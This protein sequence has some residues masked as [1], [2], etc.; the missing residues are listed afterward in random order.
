[1]SASGARFAWPL[2]WIN[3]FPG[4]GKLT[5]A[6]LLMT[7]L[8]EGDPLLIDNHSLIDP[9]ETKFSRGHPNYQQE[10]RRGREAVFKN[11]VDDPAFRTRIVIFTAALRGRRPF[12]PIY[13]ECDI[14]E[15]IRR[16][17]SPQRGG[18]ETT[19][20]SSPEVLAEMRS[21]CQLFRFD[22]VES[23]TLDVTNMG[24]EEAA[25]ALIRE[26]SRI[27]GDVVEH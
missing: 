15:N 2:I 7:L 1:M 27:I 6:K 8:D 18:T 25:K 13:L 14:K 11:L 20:L 19:K 21:R 12:L 23:I 24:P 9:V 22:G 16:I 3:G 5:I 10:R 4:T 26:V 17:T